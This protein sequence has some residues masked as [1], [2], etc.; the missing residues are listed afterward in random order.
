V[1]ARERAVVIAAL[2]AQSVGI[3]ACGWNPRRPFDRESPAV[4]QAIAALDAGDATAAANV[5]EDYLLTGRCKEGSI[6][7]PASVTEHANGGFDLGLALFRVGEAFG[8]RFG[9]EE[10]KLDDNAAP[11]APPSAP[12]GGAPGDEAKQRRSA[13][14][15]CA[16]QIVRAVAESTA[17]P[18]ELRARARYLEGNLQF[19]GTDYEEAV[20]AYDKAIALSPGE[21]DAGDPVGRDAAWNRAIAL[22][23]IEDKKDAG[24]D[25]APPDA[26]NDGA[27]SPDASEPDSG[28]PD[29]GNEGGAPDGGREPP[30][31]GPDDAG[32]DSGPPPPP[33]DAS[34]PPPPP[35][36][37]SQDERILD[38]LENA[39]T[40]QQEDAKKRATKHRVR[41]TADK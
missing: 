29:G 18:I 7:A 14:I 30:D 33:R 19:L 21:V 4:N 39:P 35:P 28:K 41:G 23:R 22:R 37:A 5:L 36:K 15:A 26:S 40:V 10:V 6:G 27:S 34:A 8:R 9:D 11:A 12:K 3:A 31:S 17:Q 20:A 38:Q 1:R 24:N 25:A 16:L 13:Q 2:F 32:E